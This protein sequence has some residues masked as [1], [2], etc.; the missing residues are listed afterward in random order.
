MNY[1]FSGHETFPM[2]LLWPRKTYEEA[3]R[4]F[5]AGEKSDFRS[6]SAMIR[7]GV[8]RNMLKSMEFW[9]KAIGILNE[10]G[11]PT[12][13]GR[14]LFGQTFGS[15]ESISV[16]DT[17]TVG[18]DPY[19]EKSASAWLFHW[20][21]ASSPWHSTTLW[22]LFN[23]F[24]RQSFTREQ[25]LAD[26]MD[27]LEREKSRGNLKQ[28]PSMKTLD[29]D[30]TTL[31]RAYCPR[32]RGVGVLRKV[33]ADLK[34]GE[35]VADSVFRELKLLAFNSSRY[36]FSRTSHVSLNQPLF[37]MTVLEYW[38]KLRA[39]QLTLD[40]NQL[41][42]M[43]GSPGK[44]FKL[45]ELSLGNYLSNLSDVTEGRLRW[46][47]QNGLRHVTCIADDGEIP[48]LHSLLMRK[49]FGKED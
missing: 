30:I 10:D 29:G 11:S 16:Q 4:A 37:A 32:T 49:A 8:G 12:V 21:V 2:R 17:D 22:Y 23:R 18:L 1:H 20:H 47:E 45:D 34:N 26:F 40:F 46:T 9:G 5:V 25:L 7:M 19:S 15:H 27:F 28:I 36:M 13:L 24:N 35:E 38:Q 41:A 33:E 3:V 42:Y 6:E 14:E 39:R 43:D 48:I 44:V 31:L